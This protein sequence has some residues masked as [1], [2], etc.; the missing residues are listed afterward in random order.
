MTG[1]D[2]KTNMDLDF[3]NFWAATDEYPIL[4]WQVQDVDL[5]VSQP[6]IGEG[7]TTSVTV[8]LTL[9][10]GSTVTASEVANYDSETA[11]ASV[12]DGTLQAN[13]VGQTELTATVAGES[14]S[15][16]V[17]VLEPPNIEFS[18]AEF[19]TEA[20]V[21]GTTVEAAVTYEN[22]GGPGSE[23]AAVTVDGETVATKTVHV[24]ADSETTESI[25]WTA[26]RNG[27]VAVDG[28]PVGELSIVAPE[29]ITLESISLPDEAA[30]GS[31]YDIEL[32]FNNTASHP[33]VDTVELRVN[34]TVET[35]ETVEIG[36]G[37]ST[38]TVTYAYDEQGIATHVV[39]HHSN[40]AT[41]TVRIIAPAAFT[42]DGLDAPE[43]VTNGE[44]GSVSVT[45]TNTGGASETQELDLLVDGELVDT[46][47]VTLDSGGSETIEFTPAFDQQ[48]EIAVTIASADDELETVVE[49]TAAADDGSPGF[50]G[51][52]ALAAIVLATVVMRRH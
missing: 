15:V 4:Q 14:D 44:D 25:Q 19:G 46:Q 10:D 31:D 13:S 52:V 11:V 12:S 47:S 36:A 33:V 42:L 6:A 48:G 17:E 29:A 34:G 20:A 32:E 50:G 27:T 45:V 1:A 9:D 24:D 5:S 49:S 28:E 26:Q 18:D 23:T 39:D 22:T 51:A 41:G 37:E 38:E 30:Q 8:E 21:D 7:E 3:E 43:T 40:D 35:T 16:T 2:A